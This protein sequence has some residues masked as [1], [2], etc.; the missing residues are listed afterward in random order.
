MTSRR[1]SRWDG[2]SL[3][4]EAAAHLQFTTD[5]TRLAEADILLASGVL[6]VLEDWNGFLQRAA[7]CLVTS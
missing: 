7:P 3:E 2:P 6:Q 1:L 4:E 5:Y